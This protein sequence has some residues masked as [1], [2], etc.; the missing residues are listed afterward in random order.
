MTTNQINSKEITNRDVLEYQITFRF[1]SMGLMMANKTFVFFVSAAGVQMDCLATED[2]ED[3]SWDAIWDSEV[4]L[5][6]FG[7]V[8]EMKIHM[9]LYDFQSRETNL[10]NFMRRLNAMFKI[11]L[12]PG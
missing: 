1:T 5:T 4:A 10:G 3:F 12:E 11:H 6:E 2:Y 7:W 8:V 9:R